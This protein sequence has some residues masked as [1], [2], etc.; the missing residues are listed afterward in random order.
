MDT[1]FNLFN[2]HPLGEAEL[3]LAVLAADESK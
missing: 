3:A 2:L 1:E